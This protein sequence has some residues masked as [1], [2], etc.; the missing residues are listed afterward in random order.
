MKLLSAFII[1][2]HIIL[3]TVTA[4]AAASGTLD[5][6]EFTCPTGA[7]PSTE[8]DWRRVCGGVVGPETKPASLGSGAAYRRLAGIEKEAVTATES[9]SE[10][11]KFMTPAKSQGCVGSCTAFAIA[12]CIE[13]LVPGLTVSEAE[14]FLRIRL[15]GKLGRSDNGIGL[16]SY[17]TLLREGVVRSEDFISYDKYN[18]YFY[19]RK[20][21]KGLAES[22]VLA[23]SDDFKDSVEDILKD[24][25][26]PS[27]ALVSPVWR[28]KPFHVK[29]RGV[30]HCEVREGYWRDQIFNCFPLKTRPKAGDDMSDDILNYFQHILNSVPI[31]VTVPV[32]D[33][34]MW[35]YPTV[36]M[37]NNYTINI[38]SPEP[39]GKKNYHAI[40]LCGYDDS[41]AVTGGKGKG[42]FRIK[43][44]WWG[45]A[46]ADKGFA[47]LS[48]AYVRKYISDAMVIL[49]HPTEMFIDADTKVGAR[50]V[51]DEREYDI[52]ATTAFDAMLAAYNATPDALERKRL[53]GR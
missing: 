34:V 48:Y 41:I 26:L 40:C 35:H 12:A 33:K 47:W 37:A 7:L 45:S 38:P 28:V 36:S 1:I 49:T 50:P 2:T 19:K 42:A 29:Y 39:S 27:T 17:V 52:V 13:Y 3:N 5:P 43:N 6:L 24:R 31:V 10:I 21:L 30:V 9:K 44:S 46:W 4:A 8:E 53:L 22:E 11:Y 51:D 15:L 25:G 16:H 18:D 14:L 20:N 32:F 23:A